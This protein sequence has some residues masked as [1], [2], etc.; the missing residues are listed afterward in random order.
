[1]FSKTDIAEQLF[2]HLNEN[3]DPS[4]K[5]GI[6]SHQLRDILAAVAEWIHSNSVEA[7]NALA[8]PEDDGSVKV[9]IHGA[10]FEDEL[11]KL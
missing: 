4:V 1:M 2:K 5:A 6:K 3:L 11:S 7:D 8:Q 9:E 10:D